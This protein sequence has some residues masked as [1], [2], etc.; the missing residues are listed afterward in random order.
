MHTIFL[1]LPHGH[2]PTI[3]YLSYQLVLCGGPHVFFAKQLAQK[4]KYLML[5][6]KQTIYGVQTQQN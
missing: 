6:V 5:C 3:T 4:G 1:Y 2:I